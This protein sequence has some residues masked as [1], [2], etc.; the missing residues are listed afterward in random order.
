MA[1]SGG[2][3]YKLVCT[4]CSKEYS[5]DEKILVCRCGNKLEVKLNIESISLTL[6]EMKARRGRAALNI[7]QRYFEFLPLLNYNQ[8]VSIGE[9]GTSLLKARRLGEKLGFSNLYIKNEITNPTGSFK[10]RPIGVGVNKVLEHGFSTV[11]TA[12][13]G[14]A[15]SSLASYSAKC[16]LKCVAFVP[17]T[18]PASK[19]SQLLMYGAK[20]V[21]LRRPPDFTGDPTVFML[22]KVYAEYG[23]IPVPSFG[24]LN[25]YQMEGAKTIGFEI[26]EELVPDHVVIPM[27]GAGLFIGNYNAF[28]Q[29]KKVGI[30]S[31][32]PVLHA[33]QGAGCAPFVKAF[34]ENK[35]I[36]TVKDPHTVA[37]GLAD[38]FT[39]DGKEAMPMLKKTGGYA[40]AVEDEPVLEAQKL[41]ARYE[42]IFAEPTG[43]ASLAG[44]IKLAEEGRIPRQE[45]VVIEVT[46]HGFKDLG[47]VEKRF[48]FPPVAEP[49]LE[50][51]K[52]VLKNFYSFNASEHITPLGYTPKFAV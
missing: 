18:A 52:E 50:N 27:G 13:S 35:P 45:T 40:V 9:G 48:S 33:V 39:W 31:S 43:S 30:T 36:E 11:A 49:E 41:L 7:H 19:V 25:P 1:D 47:I 37:G 28:D 14:N 22:K 24:T 38:P 8:T 34:V 46:G 16:D 17:S 3:K 42:G 21:P 2:Y 10:D 51:I 5:Q 20:V 4:G 12:S 15:A 32:M 44:L 29:Y 6:N 26:A 23:W